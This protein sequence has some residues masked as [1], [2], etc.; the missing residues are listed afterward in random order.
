MKNKQDESLNKLLVSTEEPIKDSFSILLSPSDIG[1]QRNHG[2]NGARYAPKA[3]INVLKKFNKH[4]INK[5]L[6]LIKVSDQNN[7]KSDFHKMQISSAEKI[8]QTIVNTSL[9][10]T[11]HLGGGHDHA[12]PLL[13]GIEK[14][15]KFNNIIIVN[16][17]AHCDTRIDDKRHSGTPFR[18]FDNEGKLDY[19]LIQY[20]IHQ[21]ANSASTLSP[22]K[23]G[24][25]NQINFSQKLQSSPQDI[26]QFVKN[27]LQDC[28]F[29]ITSKTAL[30]LSLDCDAL[31]ATAMQ[32]VSAV[33]P[34]GLSKEH[35][36]E[37]LTAIPRLEVNF[38][39][40]FLGIYEY[41]PIYDNL[42][43]AGARYLSSLIYEFLEQ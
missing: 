23:R 40:I 36:S 8:S 6:S 33:N 39:H 42:S 31:D 17:D 29:E 18:D 43:Q 38:G 1:V 19:H 22:L 7:E 13:L 12:F 10:K 15:Q 41:N 9:K 3:I 35:L 30:F 26:N 25:N 4:Q 34:Q 21:F 28:P 14:S 2:R 20:G 11:I 24:K 37:L 16:I 32:G 5:P 27:L